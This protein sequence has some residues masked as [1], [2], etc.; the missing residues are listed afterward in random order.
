MLLGIL[1]TPFVDK[2]FKE[3]LFKVCIFDLRIGG[4]II[5]ASLTKKK[6]EGLFKW[7]AYVLT[8]APCCAAELMP[9]ARVWSA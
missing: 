3:G 8:A 5:N 1:L 7:S 9:T 6:Q 4:G 2:F